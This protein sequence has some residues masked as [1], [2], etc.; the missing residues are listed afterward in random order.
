[1]KVETLKEELTSEIAHTSGLLSVR[2]CLMENL[3]TSEL[4]DVLEEIPWIT[5]NCFNLLEVMKNNSPEHYENYFSEIV[6]DLENSDCVLTSDESQYL[7]V[8][9]L[10]WA[11][12]RV[13]FR[14]S[15][16][17]EEDNE[18]LTPLKTREYEDVLDELDMV[19]VLD[20]VQRRT[21]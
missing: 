5:P 6:S 1:M 20:E 4:L 8:N 21:S 17:L 2:D 10:E 12:E 13:V 7:P 15:A 18:P 3:V 11:K 14:L 16:L 19:E 9:E